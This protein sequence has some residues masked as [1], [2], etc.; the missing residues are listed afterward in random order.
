VYQIKDPFFTGSSYDKFD[1]GNEFTLCLVSDV[2][3]I[4]FLNVWNGMYIKID[5]L[6]GFE[7]LGFCCGAVEVFAL[8]ECCAVLFG[9]LLL[10]F[11]DSFFVPFSRVKQ[12]KKNA[13]AGECVN[14]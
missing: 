7:I 2:F 12:S 4:L 6:H 13:E 1:S 8:L 9:S 14:I 10:M 11:Q 3:M 5:L